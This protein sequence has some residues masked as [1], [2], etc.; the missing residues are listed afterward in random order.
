MCSMIENQSQKSKNPGATFVDA[1]DKTE[2]KKCSDGQNH[3]QE[4]S[5]A[6]DGSTEISSRL[7]P[8]RGSFVVNLLVAASVEHR[9]V[10]RDQ[11]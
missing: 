10:L 3:W 6:F 9:I 8:R 4:E 7:V 2:K 5:V 1:I 11:R